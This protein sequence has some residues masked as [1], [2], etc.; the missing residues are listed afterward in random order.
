MTT[1]KE[2]KYDVFISY[3][4]KDSE[5][6]DKYLLP[7]LKGKKI[8][9]CIDREHF[10]IGV[11]AHQNMTESIRNSRKTLLVL[12]S[13]YLESDWST[14]EF[15]L[16]SYMDPATRAT[17]ILP[18]LIQENIS[19]PEHIHMITY[20]DF[21]KLDNYEKQ[22]ERL[23]HSIKPLIIENVGISDN[24]QTIDEMKL[25]L[26]EE[27]R[28][29]KLD[30]VDS[31]Q[32]LETIL[33]SSLHSIPQGLKE[34]TEKEI[35]KLSR[36]QLLEFESEFKKIIINYVEIWILSK[37]AQIEAIESSLNMKLQ[38]RFNNINIQINIFDKV[39]FIDNYKFGRIDIMSGINTNI[40]LRFGFWQ[41]DLMMIV[42]VLYLLSTKYF[43]STEKIREDIVMRLNKIRENSSQNIYQQIVYGYSHMGKFNN[44][45]EQMFDETIGNLDKDYQAFIDETFKS[46]TLEFFGLE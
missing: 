36:K 16:S 44:G 42:V 23:I 13:N 39:G 14:F 7:V 43:R 22:V 34:Y 45:L 30:V 3:S 21:T 41:W 26:E 20:L 40:L 33:K 38:K 32:E 25:W 8:R 35:A 15:Y 19:L 11:L 9:Y 46:I 2:Y 24:P 37:K 10:E 29:A 17:R 18:I 31:S 1:S 27:Q 5:W 12:S 6:V 28:M 4:S